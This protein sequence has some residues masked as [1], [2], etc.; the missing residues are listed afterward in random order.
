MLD[1]KA[2]RFLHR[3]IDITGGGGELQAKENPLCIGI[4]EWRSLSGKVG[5]YN[6]PIGPNR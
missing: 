4:K 1:S 2:D 3:L 5:E 6:K